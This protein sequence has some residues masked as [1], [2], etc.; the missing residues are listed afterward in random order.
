MV[1]HH[2]RIFLLE[3]QE[4]GYWVLLW[5]FSHLSLNY[6]NTALLCLFAIWLSLPLLPCI[7]RSYAVPSPTAGLS[8]HSVLGCSHPQ[9]RCPFPRVYEHTGDWSWTWLGHY[10]FAFQGLISYWPEQKLKIELFTSMLKTGKEVQIR[11]LY[12]FLLA[13]GEFSLWCI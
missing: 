8:E 5:S 7:P 1:Q 3:R 6:G 12:T 13:K 10:F 2:N 9:Y 4:W 11:V